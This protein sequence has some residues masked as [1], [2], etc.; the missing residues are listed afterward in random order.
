[1]FSGNV[2]F[3][4]GQAFGASA[5]FDALQEFVA[6]ETYDFTAASM[7]FGDTGGIDFGAARTF[8][9][10]ADFPTG[11]VFTDLDHDLS[12]ANIEYGSGSAFLTNVINQGILYEQ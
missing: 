3:A 7:Q 12:A 4:D 9:A 10:S 1:M 2:D 8:G 5:K 6:G 11:Q